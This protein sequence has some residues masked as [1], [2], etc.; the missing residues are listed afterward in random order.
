M[1]VYTYEFV[2]TKRGYGGL[3]RYGVRAHLYNI[4]YLIRHAH[5]LFILHIGHIGIHSMYTCTLIRVHAGRIKY[6]HTLVRHYYMHY[7]V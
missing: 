4:I 3:G 5:V 7:M 2:H 6:S 1:G